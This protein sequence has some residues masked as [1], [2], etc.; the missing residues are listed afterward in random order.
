MLLSK[1]TILTKKQ[2]LGSKKKKVPE[3]KTAEIRSSPKKEYDKPWRISPIKKRL[4]TKS[5]SEGKLNI[6]QTK[7]Q[8]KTFEP[9]NL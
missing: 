9:L 2:I 3:K 6:N 1:S 7:N 8:N 5:K 4:R